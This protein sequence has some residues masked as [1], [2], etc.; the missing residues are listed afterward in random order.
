VGAVANLL[1]KKFLIVL[2]PV[3]LAFTKSIVCSQAFEVPGEVY[4]IVYVYIGANIFQK[5]VIALITRKGGA[6]A[7]GAS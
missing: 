4:S 2:V 3:V 5:I 1:S 7:A 6:P